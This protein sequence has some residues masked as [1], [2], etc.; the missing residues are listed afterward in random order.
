MILLAAVVIKGLLCFGRDCRAVEGTTIPIEPTETARQFVWTS[1]DSKSIVFGTAAAKAKEI[2]LA[3]KDLRDVTLSV[4][5][6][7]ARGWPAE[8]MIALR[9]GVK[10]PQWQTMIPAKAIASLTTIRA[11]RGRY[12][13]WIAAP[14]H[15]VDRRALQLD[16]N[17]ALREIVLKPAPI[18]SGTVVRR[19]EKGDVPLAGA[20]LARA[21][22]KPLG[23]TN[24]QGAF[25]FELGEPVPEHLVVS[26]PGYGTKIVALDR[27]LAPDTTL[28]AIQLAAGHALTI[29]V[30]LPDAIDPKSVTLSLAA[31]TP[32]KYETTTLVSRKLTDVDV[33]L[34][35]V[36][37]GSYQVI[38]AG[39]DPLEHL[40]TEVTME[41]Q[42]Q[43]KTIA[44]APFHVQGTARIGQTP[45][46]E[47]T[48]DITERTGWHAEMPIR[49]G[50]FGG[51]MWQPGVL[52]PYLKLK[53]GGEPLTS[54]ELGADPS[55]WDIALKDRR[56]A[57]RIFDAETKETVTT[58]IME[59]QTRSGGERGYTSVD[60]HDGTFSILATKAGTYELRL[61][62]PGYLNEY[63]KFD[64]AGADEGTRTY[65]FALQHGMQATIEVVNAT[66]QP[67]PGA[68][69]DEGL[70]ADGHNPEYIYRTDAAGTLTL[71]FRADET[72]TLYVMPRDGS[73]AVARLSAPRD[74][75]PLQ[76]VVPPV[77][78]SL[79][80]KMA[81]DPQF[82]KIANV[83][84]RYNGAMLPPYAMRSSGVTAQA[85]DERIYQRLPAGL[86]EIWAV[87]FPPGVGM[88]ALVGWMPR[89]PPVRAGV[90]GQAVVEVVAQ[91]VQ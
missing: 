65:D 23:A 42:D 54:P 12:G 44:V 83:V 56:I 2:D 60:V 84:M 46:A 43:E 76:I 47:G 57:G 8:T 35:D 25:R 41:E 80:V 55:V 28:G 48:I 89:T 17:V 87:Q 10:S 7:A 37:P 27:Q 85:P 45:I 26:H 31:D 79:H 5:G 38:L 62:A 91:P 59:V 49:D 66:G 70:S 53:T 74:D 72:R 58:G 32:G 81:T 64:V 11:P 1:A 21:D 19:D 14:H 6:S 39:V 78:G 29:H 36:A 33:V 63:A 13:L 90:P 18:V 3:S 15:L 22:G 75:K 88:E 34:P 67:I 24:E 40:E 16:A 61:R 71:Q 4:R 68:E 69:V 86:Y 73:F 77:A 50:A 20:Q 51:V 9:T 52:R 30:K 82:G